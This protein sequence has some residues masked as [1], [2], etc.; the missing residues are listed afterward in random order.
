MESSALE[1][2]RGYRPQFLSN[3]SDFCSLFSG[4]W[5]KTS[6]VSLEISLWEL[7][8]KVP[9]MEDSWRA[10]GLWP[11]DRSPE[12]PRLQAEEAVISGYTSQGQ[13]ILRC[14]ILTWQMYITHIRINGIRGSRLWWGFMILPDEEMKAT[15]GVWMHGW[16][17]ICTRIC[18]YFSQ[19]DYLYILQ[20]ISQLLKYYFTFFYLQLYSQNLWS[21]YKMHFAKHTGINLNKHNDGPTDAQQAI[22]ILFIFCQRLGMFMWNFI[23]SLYKIYILKKGKSGVNVVPIPHKKILNLLFF[24]LSLQCWW[25]AKTELD[26]NWFGFPSTSFS[27]CPGPHSQRA[28]FTVTAGW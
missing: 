5:Q 3:M 16:I 4:G 24:P 8:S 2:P 27:L 23:Q 14:Q 15:V 26:W 10:T 13:L 11:G 7:A 28:H 9:E 22:Y 21:T 1:T 17:N 6:W 12:T 20:N 19:L 18:I 25:I